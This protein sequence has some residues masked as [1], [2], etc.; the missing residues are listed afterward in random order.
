[1]VLTIYGRGVQ[2]YSLL[3]LDTLNKHLSPDPRLLH[4]LFG[5]DWPSGFG[6]EGVEENGYIHVYSPGV[7]ADNPLG[8]LFFLYKYEYFVTLV[9]CCVFLPLRMIRTG[10]V[11]LYGN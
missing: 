9:I 2:Y 3:I 6:K 4:M 7:G 5:F 1:M 10:G 11:S 8:L